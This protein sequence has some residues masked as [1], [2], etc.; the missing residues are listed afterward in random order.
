MLESQYMPLLMAGMAAIALASIVYAIIYPFVSG[1]RQKDK[2]VSS[3]IDARARRLGA[4][5]AEAQN[6]RK[7][8]VADSLKEM[9]NRQKQREK[10][11]LRQ[12][13]QRAGLSITP[14]DYYVMSAA[15]GLI[16]CG[17]AFALVSIPPAGLLVVAIVMGVGLP[18]FVLK[19]MM[20]RRQKKFVAELANAIDIIVRGVKSG[21]PLNECVQVV[22]RE[23]PEPLSSEFREVVEQQRLGVP[24][25]EC[26]DRMCERM[27]IAEVRFLAI[28]IAIQQQSGGNLSEALGN[29]SSVLRDRFM[30]AMKVKALS[31]EAKASAAVLAS[32]PP[33]V[34]TM[35][36]MLSPDYIEPLFTTPHGNFMLAGG[37]LWML[38]G[39]MIMRKMINFKF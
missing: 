4:A 14:R 29:L 20:A 31:A 13:L 16:A 12:K 11:T 37:G 38:T 32:L 1:D 25:P 3:V 15:A 35:V 6:N 18:Q 22:A 39:I 26:L 36:Y 30:L 19:K 23:S 9:E 21:L 7:K 24:L 8:N 5:S 27:P 28:V 33:G 34:M 17:A 2:R 10:V